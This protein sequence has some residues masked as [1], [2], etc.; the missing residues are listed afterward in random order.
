[1]LIACLVVAGLAVGI[2]QIASSNTIPAGQVDQMNAQAQAQ[3]MKVEAENEAAATARRT[4]F[5]GD[6]YSQG[7]GASVKSK[8]WTSIVS[9]AFGWHEVN[10][11]RGGT[12]YLNE[13]TSGCGLPTCPNYVAMVPEAIGTNPGRVVVAGG[14]NDFGFDIAEVGPMI[15][16]TY[17]DLRAGL[18]TATIV[19]I[20]PST[21]GNITPKIIEYD[22][23]VQR[24][25]AAAGAQYISLIDPDPI[26]KTMAAPDGVHVNDAGHA[27]IAAAIERKLSSQS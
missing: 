16:K 25:A 26:D 11:A 10:L 6:S 27:A 19:A 17:A 14:Q 21:I 20:G 13:S 24:A 5:I 22:A 2:N 12:G 3:V 23:R 18:P 8:R 7:T 9:K 15:D 1:V 4:V